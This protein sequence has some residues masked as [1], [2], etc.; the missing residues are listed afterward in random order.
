MVQKTPPNQNLFND[1]LNLVGSDLVSK[2]KAPD[3][4]TQSPKFFF[5][6]FN[7]WNYVELGPSQIK[8][9][10]SKVHK[11]ICTKYIHIYRNSITLLEL[12]LL[13]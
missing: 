9:L 4:G 3:L 13:L 1:S 10:L 2:M 12:L 8:D 5:Y 11:Q 7:M 6:F